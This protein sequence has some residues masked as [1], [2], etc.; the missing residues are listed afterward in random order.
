M[1]AKPKKHKNIPSRYSMP[2]T[3]ADMNRIAQNAIS[4]KKRTGEDLATDRTT[5]VQSPE[6]WL[7]VH[8]RYVDKWCE[9]FGHLYYNEKELEE[10]RYWERARPEPKK[11]EKLEEYITVD[12]FDKVQRWPAGMK[13]KLGQQVTATCNKLGVEVKKVEVN[14]RGYNSVNAYPKQLLETVYQELHTVRMV[15]EF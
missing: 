2:L 7:E 4:H 9:K 6:Y 8:Y 12:N 15:N 5:K 10:Y 14:R 13:I 1:R 11:P 3:R